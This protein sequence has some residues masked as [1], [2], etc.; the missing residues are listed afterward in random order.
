[1]RCSLTY[2]LVR[3]PRFAPGLAAACIVPTS[4]AMAPK[5]SEMQQLPCPGGCAEAMSKKFAQ[6]TSRTRTAATFAAPG[7]TGCKFVGAM[8]W[9]TWMGLSL[10]YIFQAPGP[11]ME[12]QQR[13]LSST[14]TTFGATTDSLSKEELKSRRMFFLSSAVAS[15]FVLYL[16]ASL[17]VWSRTGSFQFNL[18]AFIP[19]R[20]CFD[21]NCLLELFLV[22]AEGTSK[23]S[24]YC[25]LCAPVTHCWGERST[26]YELSLRAGQPVEMV[27]VED[28]K[29]FT[30]APHLL[31]TGDVVVY[32]PSILQQLCCWTSLN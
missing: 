32:V 10:A 5:S 21:C 25:G 20:K 17:V 18:N 6:R 31:Q 8:L 19:C 7:T 16:I 15:I 13:M 4:T 29:I 26:K 22:P 27:S 2:L 24:C 12:V 11:V 9:L 14:N 23:L 28:A 1:M 3:L 30:K